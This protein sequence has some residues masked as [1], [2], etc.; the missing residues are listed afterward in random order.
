MDKKKDVEQPELAYRR[1]N[2]LEIFERLQ[3]LS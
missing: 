3:D 1:K 2:K